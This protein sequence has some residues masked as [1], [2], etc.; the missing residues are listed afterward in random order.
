ME[1]I[2]GRER[3]FSPDIEALFSEYVEFYGGKVVEKQED[4]DT[5][6]SNADF[7]FVQ[8]E[9]IA[10]LK[11]FQ[12]DLFS[13][14]EDSARMLGMLEKWIKSG[15]LTF[16]E[17]SKF[18]F[19]DKPLPKECVDDMVKRASKTIERAIYK[20]NKQI[21]ETKKTFKK[22]AAN[23]VVFLVNDGNYFFKHEG[24]IA[25]IANI[26]G[27]KFRDASFD[28][29]VYLTIN[30]STFKKDSELDYQFWVPIYSKV[31]EQGNTIVSNELHTFINDF[32]KCFLD[33]FL[34]IKTGEKPKE[35]KE[36]DSVNDAVEEL[37]QHMYIPKGFIYK[38]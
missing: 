5:D 21:A 10:E 24:F 1:E 20:A 28:V 35:Y 8:P 12:K 14:S 22:E 23:G 7:I 31:D 34:T 2:Q 15:F 17:W 25:V 11:T 33:E 30:Q 29:V 6:R 19:H 37:H 16:E 4:N 13:E 18:V 9:I 38:K 27:R 32:G 36:L 3:P 26:I